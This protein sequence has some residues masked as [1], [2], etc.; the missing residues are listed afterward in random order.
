MKNNMKVLPLGE[1]VLIE[2]KKEEDKTENGIYLPDGSA[3]EK[4]KK[5]E[6]V[7]VGDSDKIRVKKGQEVIYR[8]YAPS[9]YMGVIKG[10]ECVMIMVDDILAV[11]EK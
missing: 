9:E 5:G 3:A 11:V 4:C 8:R 6:V 7:A 10:K 2:V 1:N